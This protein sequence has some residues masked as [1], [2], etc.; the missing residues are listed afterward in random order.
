MRRYAVIGAAVVLAALVAGA[1]VGLHD[2]TDIATL[3]YADTTAGMP[4][5]LKQ[6]EKAE[7]LNR[8]QICYGAMVQG[9][10]ATTRQF[11]GVYEDQRAAGV[12]HQDRQAVHDYISQLCV[13]D[14]VPPTAPPR[15]PAKIVL[16]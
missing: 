14:L 1:V 8:G 9:V 16:G 10:D 4:E 2:R 3:S 15:F 11:I 5:V 13:K 12:L 7:V 6:V